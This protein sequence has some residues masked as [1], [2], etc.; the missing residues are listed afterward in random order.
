MKKA[1]LIS[2][3][4]WYKGRLEYVEKYLREHGYEVQIW[5]S[6]FLH[7]KKERVVPIDGFNYI[8]VP[9]YKKNLS[10]ARMYSHYIFAQKVYKVLKSEKPDIVYANIPPNSVA[11]VCGEYKLNYP[12]TKLIFDII[13]MWPESYTAQRILKTPFSLWAEYRDNSL[14]YAD[15]IFTECE[16]YHKFLPAK[17]KNKMSVLRLLRED[18]AFT[19]IPEWT[20]KEIEIGYLGSI[21]NII[22]IDMIVKLVSAISKE[23][24]VNFH[25]VGGGEKTNC[26]VDALTIAGAV[27]NYHGVIFDKEGMQRIIGNCHFAINMMKPSVCVGLTTK[28]L[29]YFQLGVPLFNTIKGDTANI[30]SNYHCGFNVE[31]VVECASNIVRLDKERYNEMRYNTKKA[32]AEL[33]TLEVFYQNLDVISEIVH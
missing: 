3:F 18:K 5:T 15:H 4:G 2:C 33:F 16:L 29:D 1:I 8:H 10:L 11:H 24:I 17:Y 9:S 6:D 21:N 20:G 7:F 22:D 13:D 31:D 30:V 27:V 12:E 26:F 32:F 19:S 25:I 14:G 23:M 28:S